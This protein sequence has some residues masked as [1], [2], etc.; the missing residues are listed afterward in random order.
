MA[1][2]VMEAEEDIMDWDDVRP[3][4]KPSVVVGDNLATLAEYD[5][6]RT[7]NTRQAGQQYDDAGQLVRVAR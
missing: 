7:L 2:K 1:V 5:A 6:K 4:P 3:K